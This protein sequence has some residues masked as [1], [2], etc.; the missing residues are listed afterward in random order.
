MIVSKTEGSRQETTAV[1]LEGRVLGPLKRKR[2]KER[3]ESVIGNNLKKE[4]DAYQQ[5]D[6]L[7]ESHQQLS[8]QFLHR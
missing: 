4:Y 3:G 7:G 2:E 5:E 8:P 6:N 1:V